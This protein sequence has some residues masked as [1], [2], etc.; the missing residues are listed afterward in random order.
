MLGKFKFDKEIFNMKKKS[1]LS[2][3]FVISLLPMFL[4]QY[5]AAKGVQEIT[6]LINLV[7]PIGLFSVC[8]FFVGVLGEF[9]KQNIGKI[10]GAVGVLGVVASEIYQYFTWHTLTITGEISLQ[11]SL[12]LAFPEFYFGL[13]VSLVMVV[14]YFVIEINIKD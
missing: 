7:N 1:I 10:F 2:L 8:V 14:A 5:G 11:H 3:L 12:H 4:N 13:I 9:K 6:G